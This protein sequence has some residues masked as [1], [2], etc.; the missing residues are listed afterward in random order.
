MA[1]PKPRPPCNISKE[2]LAQ[3]LC[4]SVE[5]EPLKP[6]VKS[7]PLK[8][9]EQSNTPNSNI[10]LIRAIKTA[11]DARNR[12]SDEITKIEVILNNQKDLRLTPETVNTITSIIPGFKNERITSSWNMKTGPDGFPDGPD[13]LNKSGEVLKENEMFHLFSREAILK[14]RKEIDE[15]G[16][17][18]FISFITINPTSHST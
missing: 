10:Y 4:Q 18:K 14:S 8:P 13:R 9:E 6:A 16:H 7:K 3:L 12:F 15:Y 17:P 1:L 5:P 2:K 11:E